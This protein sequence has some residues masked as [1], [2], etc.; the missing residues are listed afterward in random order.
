MAMIFCPSCEEDSPG[1]GSICQTCGD[2]LVLR[3]T[4]AGNNDDV[5]Q[6]SAHT[7]ERQDDNGMSP[8]DMAMLA[9]SM[10]GG[11]MHG[12]AMIDPSMLASLANQ[13]RGNPNGGGAGQTGTEDLVGMLPPEAFDPQAGTIG[14]R[15]ASQKALD[16]LKRTVLLPESAELFDAQ[17]CLFEQQRIDDPL[18]PLCMP[19]KSSLVLNAVPGEFLYKKRSN[20]TNA[21]SRCSALVICS[22]RTVKGGKLSTKT[23]SEISFLRQHRMP[24]ICYVERGDG[25]TFVQKALACQ[26][27]GETAGN[28]NGSKEFDTMCI[29]VIVGN[30]TSG[31]GKEIWPYTMQ[32][33]GG[34][35]H[36]FGLAVPVVMIRRDDGIR[37]LQ[38]SSAAEKAT[39]NDMQTYTP[40]QISIHSKE[41]DSHTCPVCTDS[42]APGDTIIRLPLCGHVF[43]ESCALAWLTS[44]NTCP[45]CRKE[46]PTDDDDYER[47]RRRREATAD[48]EQADSNINGNSFYG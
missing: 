17:V 20:P 12:G 28:D 18:T 27:A 25:V 8:L 3:P 35:A 42:Y 23:L 29:G 41:A 2:T 14:S 15:A 10:G 48:A 37:L 47:G 19:S 31:P 13:L 7:L 32:D 6:Q 43:H 9:T 24:F 34:E 5:T 39:S 26:R 33:N 46:L 36:K 1:C 22:P 4:G 44:H 21:I 40:C 11:T 38:W 16:N 30:A 45:F